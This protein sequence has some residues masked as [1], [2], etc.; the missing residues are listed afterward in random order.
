MNNPQVEA[1][2]DSW[3]VGGMTTLQAAA[4]LFPLFRFAVLTPTFVRRINGVG[5]PPQA[6]EGL[7]YAAIVHCLP[8]YL[9]CF[10]TRLLTVVLL[11]VSDNLRQLEGGKGG[12]SSHASTV[13]QLALSAQVGV[14]ANKIGPTPGPDFLEYLSR[15][16]VELQGPGRGRAGGLVRWRHQRL[17]QSIA[18][19]LG[20]KLAAQAAGVDTAVARRVLAREYA[21]FT[22][23]HALEA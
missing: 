21:T 9:R 5:E 6:L 17:V 23:S 10:K 4:A 22:A 11:R 3:E 18:E 7:L 19:G 20:L 14:Q 8:K 15:R 2:L 13:R 1:V 12:K 16:A